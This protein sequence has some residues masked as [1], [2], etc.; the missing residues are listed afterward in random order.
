MGPSRS[1]DG[2]KADPRAVLEDLKTGEEPSEVTH[3]LWG[4]LSATVAAA[5]GWQLSRARGLD[6]LTAGAG[7]GGHQRQAA[8]SSP[9][10]PGATAAIIPEAQEAAPRRATELNPGCGP[11]AGDLALAVELCGSSGPLGC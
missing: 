8:P 1:A 11:A 10:A 7:Q 9:S 6:A 3:E 4:T 5:V 2:Q